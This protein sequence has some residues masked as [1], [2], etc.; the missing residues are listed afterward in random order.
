MSDLWVGLLLGFPFGVIGN[1]LVNH[2]WELLTRF[3]AYATA[4]RLVGT[5]D[6]YNISDGNV[7]SFLPNALTKISAESPW[8]SVDS[9]V[10]HVAGEDPSGRHHLEAPPGPACA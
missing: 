9:H 7:E 6:F 4:H 8:W 5:W 10:L 3:R 1:V 2:Y